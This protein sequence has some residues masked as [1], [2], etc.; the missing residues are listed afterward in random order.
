MANRKG[1]PSLYVDDR[2]ITVH[3]GKKIGSVTVHHIKSGTNIDGKQRYHSGTGELMAQVWRDRY[4]SMSYKDFLSNVAP[5]LRG[6]GTLSGAPAKAGFATPK[7][8]QPS[9]DQK[10]RYRENHE[11]RV[12]NA[13]GE[14]A[15]KQQMKQRNAMKATVHYAYSSGGRATTA[16]SNDGITYDYVEGD[17]EQQFN[18]VPQTPKVKGEKK[19]SFRGTVN[20]TYNDM[21]HAKGPRYNSSQFSTLLS[22]HGIKVPKSGDAREEAQK[23]HRIVAG[24]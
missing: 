20:S 11:R 17:V 21:Y 4:H 18:I 3:T 22:G 13:G 14:V 2:R 7:K 24:E 1:K 6:T 9:A 16:P 12:A 23:I 5:T 19:K 15:Y 8:Y 10:A